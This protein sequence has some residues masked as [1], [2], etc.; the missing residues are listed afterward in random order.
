MKALVYIVSAGLAVCALSACSPSSGSGYEAVTGE[1]P[2]ASLTAEEA[3]VYFGSLPTL[4]DKA[5][6]SATSEGAQSQ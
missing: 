3:S 6:A 2:A 4:A 1:K 5:N